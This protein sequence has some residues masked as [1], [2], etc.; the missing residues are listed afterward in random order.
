MRI[1]LERNFTMKKKI[2]YWNIKYPRI[3][4]SHTYSAKYGGD[5]ILFES[6]KPRT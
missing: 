1:I 5:K 3:V 4:K 6:M 2:Y